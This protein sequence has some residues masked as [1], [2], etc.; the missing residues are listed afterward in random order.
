MKVNVR[1][2]KVVDVE[3]EVDDKYKPLSDDAFWVMNPF[4]AD[5]LSN[6]MA[7]DIENSEEDIE[8]IFVEDMNGNML[9]EG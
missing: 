5:C 6:E 9:F 7:A 4:K 3:M 2:R 8:V 1:I